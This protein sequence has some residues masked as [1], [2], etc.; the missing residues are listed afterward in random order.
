MQGISTKLLLLLFIARSLSKSDNVNTQFK[1]K[2]S[3]WKAL[4]A[5]LNVLKVSPQS[6]NGSWHSTTHRASDQQRTNEDKEPHTPRSNPTR[7]SNLAS[8]GLGSPQMPRASQRH[9]KNGD[10]GAGNVGN[11]TKYAS[12]QGE[13]EIGLSILS[14]LKLLMNP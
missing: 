10:E 8:R 3:K 6:V 5:T 9:D 14:F 7:S 1:K 13:G 11:T 12:S 4:P 2:T